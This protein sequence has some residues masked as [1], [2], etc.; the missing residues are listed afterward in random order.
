MM[1]MNIYIY[2]LEDKCCLYGVLSE[3]KGLSA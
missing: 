1:D 3:V 2:D